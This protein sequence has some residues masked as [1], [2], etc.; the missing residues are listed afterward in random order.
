MK[1]YEISSKKEKIQTLYSCIKKKEFYWK[2]FLNFLFFLSFFFLF[3]FWHP[4]FES[5]TKEADGSAAHVNSCSDFVSTSQ[6]EMNFIRLNISMIKRKTEIEINPSWKLIRF[7][8]DFLT[9]YFP[10]SSFH[11]LS[12]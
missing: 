1:H 8:S 9:C 2:T 7:L 5:N 11:L 6:S 12:K 4:Q 3:V 10:T